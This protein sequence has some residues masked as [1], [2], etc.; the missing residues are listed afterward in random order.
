MNEILTI[1]EELGVK[2]G[3]EIASIISIITAAIFIIKKFSELKQTVDDNLDYTELRKEN[4]DLAHTVKV[5]AT[6]LKKLREQVTHV[7]QEDI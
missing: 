7:K 3:P 2:Y 5:Q 1:F 6:E 4:K